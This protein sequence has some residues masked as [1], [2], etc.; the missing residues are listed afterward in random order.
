VRGFSFP[1]ILRGQFIVAEQ[2][3]ERDFGSKRN[4]CQEVLELLMMG[5]KAARNT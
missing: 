4:K 1:F 2:G 5:R 3:T